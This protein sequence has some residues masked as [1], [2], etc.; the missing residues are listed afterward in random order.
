MKYEVLRQLRGRV[1][2]H[3]APRAVVQLHGNGIVAQ[4]DRLQLRRGLNVAVEVLRQLRLHGEALVTDSALVR[5]LH[6]AGSWGFLGLHRRNYL[7]YG[8]T[9][10][11]NGRHS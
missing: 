1:E 3:V 10:V 11:G 6:L 8:G 9:A 2:L 7:G 5:K 4:L